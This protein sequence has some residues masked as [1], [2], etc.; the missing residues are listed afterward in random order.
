MRKI[1]KKFNNIDS[2]CVIKTKTLP[3]LNYKPPV[4]K[5]ISHII[6]PKAW[7]KTFYLNQRVSVLSAV[8]GL[9]LAFIFGGWAVLNTTDSFAKN[10]SDA[11]DISK[12]QPMPLSNLSLTENTNSSQENNVLFNTPIQFL[13]SY[14]D[15]IK[16]P[17]IISQRKQKIEQM[18]KDRKSPLYTASETIA[19]QEHWKLILA[20]AFAESTLGKNCSDNN[21]S[22]IGVAPGHR[23]WRSY[24]SY[25]AW[26]VDF[27]SL[28]DRRYNNWSL[29]EMCGVYVQPCNKNWLLAT[30]QILT[31]IKQRGIE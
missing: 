12:N 10:E 19:L 1:N 25:N 3:K 21:C 14:F 8:F 5:V 24:N 18:L 9:F 31:D 28:L 4:V 26:V 29:T 6:E 13:E 20:I 7:Y 23:L 27:N 16:E 17:E 11:Y 2:V 15:N 22:N 30:E